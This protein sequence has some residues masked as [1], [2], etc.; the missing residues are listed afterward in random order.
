MFYNIVFNL[1]HNFQMTLENVGFYQLLKQ[2]PVVFSQLENS[3][4]NYQYQ[5][6][7]IVDSGAQ[8][9][10]HQVY[11]YCFGVFVFCS[12]YV[13]IA[14][15]VKLLAQPYFTNVA[16]RKSE[17]I[18]LLI[19]IPI[20]TQFQC[21]YLFLE[22]LHKASENFISHCCWLNKMAQFHL[23]WLDN[24]LTREKNRGTCLCTVEMLIHGKIDVDD[25]LLYIFTNFTTSKMFD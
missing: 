25:N 24:S 14:P 5:K 2:L 7:F 3:W 9:T 20:L 21:L 4:I 8:C 22:P 10:G 17:N 11:V 1:L 15:V 6:S 23:T 12:V 18:I 13:F 19:T 16:W